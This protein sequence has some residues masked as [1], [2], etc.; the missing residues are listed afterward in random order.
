MALLEA[1]ATTA[2]GSA[3]QAATSAVT[4]AVNNKRKYQYWQKQQKELEKYQIAAE[5]RQFDYNKELQDYAFQK[6][7]EQWQREN[8]YNTPSAQME[9]YRQAGLNAN[10]IYGQNN[11]AASSPE[12]SVGSGVGSGTAQN[13][14]PLDIEGINIDPALM[15][16][17]INETK[18][19]DA[20]VENINADT[21]KKQEETE[22]VAE[23]TRGKK[24]ENDFKQDLNPI[25]LEKAAADLENTAKQGKLIDA[26]VKN[27]NLDSALKWYEQELKRL[28]IQIKRVDASHADELMQLRI[29]RENLQLSFVNHQ[30]GLMAKQIAS[31]DDE[32]KARLALSAAETLNRV[33]FANLADERTAY[34]QYVNKMNE[35]LLDPT[36][37]TD[38]QT[39]MSALIL[40]NLNET[41]FM[42]VVREVRAWLQGSDDDKKKIGD[43]N[44]TY[45]GS[46][47]DNEI[48]MPSEDGHHAVPPPREFYDLMDSFRGRG[49]RGN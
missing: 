7:L 34:Q 45:H 23:D 41:S 35:I 44:S 12:M 30:I 21:E 24:I 42:D 39:Y 3:A 5:K 38:N 48:D 16:R 15:Q 37:D 8:E 13:A 31:Y 4:S 18:L 14:S 28:D 49:W 43:D 33:A 6:N 40:K 17:L 11:L 36:S 1:A 47:H 27:T 46:I 19:A 26:E 2:L 25:S 22:N 32:L 29:K 9:R 20:N 10:L